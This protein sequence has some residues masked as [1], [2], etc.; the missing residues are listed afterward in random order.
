RN[1]GQAIESVAEIN[2]SQESFASAIDH[3]AFLLQRSDYPLIYGLSR[4]ATPG[5]RAAIALAERLGGAIDTTA[6]LCHGPSIMALQEVGE[7]TCT[8]GEIR[9]RAD[10][11]IFWG[12]HPATSHPRHAE[13]YSVFPQG[14][15]IPA[16]RSGRTIVMVG[17]ASQVKDWRLDASGAEPDFVVPVDGGK[18]FE[19]LATLRMMLRGNADPGASKEL[20]RLFDCMRRC[21]YGVIFFGLGITES[22]MWDGRTHA[23]TGHI[24]VAALLQLV[25]ELNDVTR[26]TARRMRIQGDVS[27]ADNVLCW[28]T[29]YPFAVDMSRGYPRYNSGEYSANELLSQQNTD[30]C[31]LV[32]A[33]TVPCF[34]TAAQTHLQSIPT[35]VIDYPGVPLNFV[36][37]VRFTTSVYG[38]HAAGTVY[39]MDNVPVSLRALMKSTAP[40]DGQVLSALLNQVTLL[41]ER[42]TDHGL[43][44][45][46]A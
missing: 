4:S 7:V 31:V 16:G 5:Q 29:G 14:R 3:A 15:F 37:T 26:F 11:V 42:D 44:C 19:T 36:P 8:L 33:E 32:G 6:S 10:L 13:R 39:R 46:E 12:C 18:D 27:G 2:G 34:S 22:S 30:L 21:R 45:G 1:H 17:D 43:A 40:T 25:A 28:Q 20:C 24:N 41:D 35:I 9:N 38:L 23:P